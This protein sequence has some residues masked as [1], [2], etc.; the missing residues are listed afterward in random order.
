MYDNIGNLISEL[1]FSFGLSK[2]FI[3]PRD[4]FEAINDGSLFKRGLAAQQSSEG[5]SLSVVPLTLSSRE[6]TLPANVTVFLWLEVKVATAPYETFQFVHWVPKPVLEESR[7]RGDMRCSTY[8][9]GKT[10]LLRLTLSYDPVSIAHRVWYAEDF[11]LATGD[12]D[13]LPMLKKFAPMI[14]FDA[15]LYLCARILMRNGLLPPEQQ[16]SSAAL[17]GLNAIASYAQGELTREGGW[18][19]MYEY[20]I[21]AGKEVRGRARRP[22]LAR[23]FSPH[24]RRTY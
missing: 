10:G 23:G 4:C 20:D 12:S 22:I 3:G 17:A 5:R 7:L 15:Q 6:T 1:F 19:D 11:A 24:A 8:R 18:N 14:K 13:P 21:R 16:L 2:E 9:D